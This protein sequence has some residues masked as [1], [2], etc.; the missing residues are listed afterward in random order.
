MCT[1][2]THLYSSGLTRLT[3]SH[4]RLY[5]SARGDLGLLVTLTRSGRPGDNNQIERELCVRAV[6]ANVIWIRGCERLGWVISEMT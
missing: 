5:S 3:T 6:S 1:L 2:A 4:L